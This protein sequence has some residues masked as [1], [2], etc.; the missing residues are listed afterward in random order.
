[1]KDVLEGGEGQRVGV[2]LG[3]N[4]GDRLAH[5]CAARER[6]VAL[7]GFVGPLRSAPLYETEPLDCT[8]GSQPFLNTVIEFG[9]RG[10]PV[11]LLD[12]LLAIE[13]G[14]G[15]PSKHPR[16]APRPLDLDILYFGNLTL[17]NE[18]IVIPHPRLHLR[19]FVL[20]PLTA[21]R[22]EL[23]LPGQAQSVAALLAAVRDDSA[24]RLVADAW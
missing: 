9:Y 3:S 6:L 12:A 18:E 16:N 13:V 15:R 17:R 10:H 14:L 24:V 20:A 1:M 5:L 19:R 21:L 23:I 22:P 7:P 4:L 11:T 2:G 8:P